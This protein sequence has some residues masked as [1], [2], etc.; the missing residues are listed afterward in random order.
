MIIRGIHE[1]VRGKILRIIK[2]N[3]GNKS[4]GWQTHPRIEPREMEYILIIMYLDLDFI[5]IL[6]YSYGKDPTFVIGRYL[7]GISGRSEKVWEKRRS[8]I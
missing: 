4:E 7:Y 6:L 2:R 1:I 8:K 5:S 3:I